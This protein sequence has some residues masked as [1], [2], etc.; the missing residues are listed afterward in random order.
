M[1]IRSCK[2]IIILSISTL[3]SHPLLYG[4]SIQEAQ[5]YDWFDTS[6]GKNNLSIINGTLH[7]NPH[8]IINKEKHMYFLSDDFSSG[9]ILYDGQPYYNV[10][11]KYDIYN[12]VLVLKPEGN[13]DL[14]AVNIIPEKTKSFFIKNRNFINLGYDRSTTQ[15]DF[16][17]GFYELN[18]VGKEFSFY[19][20]YHKKMTERIHNNALYS[21][22]EDKNTFFIN[23]QNTFHEINSQNDIT[24]LF[25]KYKT[26]IKEFYSANGKLRSENET[27][28]MENIMK[29]INTL[30]LS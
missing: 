16:I 17:K 27:R 22:F 5:L 7:N 20:K 21:D 14:I 23:Y 26:Q 18:L 11:L 8:R 30:F 25:P 10:N 4:Q 9:N 3:T 6:T 29:F 13:S 1:N 19:I 24:K 15:P 2:L 28:F 12:D